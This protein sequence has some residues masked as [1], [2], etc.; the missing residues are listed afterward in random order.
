MSKPS[1]N[2]VWHSIDQTPNKG[3]W[4]SI[5]QSPKIRLMSVS[6]IN[7]TK[8]DYQVSAENIVNATDGFIDEAKV[9]SS[10]THIEINNQHLIISFSNGLTFDCGVVSGDYPILRYTTEGIEAKYN[11][12]PDSA[13]KL[14]VPTKDISLSYDKLTEEQKNEIKF[15]FSDFTEQEIVL[16]Q[17]PAI[18]AAAQCETIISLVNNAL[19]NIEAL[20][21]LIS[22]KEAKRDTSEQDRLSS[23]TERKRQETIRISNEESRKIAEQ[24][25]EQSETQRV[26]R[27]QV[28]VNEEISRINAETL[29]AQAESDRKSEYS[30]IVNETNTAKDLALDVANHPNYVGTDFYVYQWD[31]STQSYNKLDI[32]LRPEAFNIFR[33]FPSIP[34]MNN[35]KDNVPE[36]KFVV[37]NGDVEVE[38][39][40][41]LYVRTSEGFDYLVDMSGMRGFSG[42]TPQFIIGNVVSSEPDVPANVSLSESGV[43]SSG[44]PIYAINISVPKGKSGTSF[45]IHA[46]YDTLDDLSTAIPDGSDINGCCAVGTQKPYNYYFWG[47][48]SDGES[49][50]QDHGRLEGQKGDPYTW[51]DLT[52]EQKETMAVN[53]G[54]Y[55]FENLMINSDGHLIINIP[56]N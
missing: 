28:R 33:T 27:E 4:Y 14:L 5:V 43:D 38:D 24:Q 53:T 25:R 15:H 11:R 3:E 40:G 20:N 41:K 22:D 56:D 29:R 54:R 42:K 50:W 55:F 21:N 2:K 13:Y 18:D 31:R 7:H 47:K 16:L 12:E 36:G 37:I 19:S 17:K 51:E 26:Q 49:G 30:Q 6:N 48:G 52:P 39:T 35:N 23:E 8:T 44:N 1:T 46:T 10:I 34:E 45:N 32:C 9:Y